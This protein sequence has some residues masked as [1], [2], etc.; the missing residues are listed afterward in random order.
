MNRTKETLVSPIQKAKKLVLEYSYPKGLLEQIPS[1]GTYYNGTSSVYLKEDEKITPE[2]LSKS[3]SYYIEIED[4]EISEESIPLGS[5]KSKGLPHL[6]N[7]NFWPKGTYF[8]AQLNIEEFKK[9]DIEN[10]FPDRGM[11]YFF[12]NIEGEFIVKY[13]EGPI[14][15]LKITDYPDAKTLPEA[16]YYLE[17]YRD[18]AYQLS[19]KP[20]F[21]FYVAG[22]AY[23]Y[24]TIANL[25]PKDLSD[26]L[27]QMFKAE[28][29]TWSPSFRIFGRP[30]FWQGE[31]EEGFDFD[32]YEEED[33]DE[34]ESIEVKIENESTEEADLLI[35]HTEIGEGNIHIRMNRKDLKDKKFEKAYSTY[36]GT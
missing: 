17:E 20:N 33:A 30:L 10:S 27:K 12:D 22:D 4:K 8:L 13:Y 24:R 16:K 26:Q 7:A 2:I 23:D 9:Y 18:V 21:I 35:F 6:P 1:E 31:D 11:L 15:D 28:L 5:S 25:I 19:F 32:E 36:S 3:L 14:S 29:A 34:D